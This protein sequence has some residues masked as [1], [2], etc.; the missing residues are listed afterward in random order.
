MSKGFSSVDN[1]LDARFS[2]QEDEDARFLRKY[3]RMSLCSARD[4]RASLMD[5]G[6]SATGD[7]VILSK[8]VRKEKRKQRVKR[9]GRAGSVER[10]TNLPDARPTSSEDYSPNSTSR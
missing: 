4:S 1:L 9:E 3:Q 6:Q 8:A 5:R 2:G 10:V 7:N